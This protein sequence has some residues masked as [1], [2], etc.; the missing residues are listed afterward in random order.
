MLNQKRRKQENWKTFSKQLF[1]PPETY[2]KK[3]YKLEALFPIKLI[4]S[5]SLLK[6]AGTV[7][8]VIR[9]MKASLSEGGEADSGL[10]FERFA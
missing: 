9:T 10:I 8:N 3:N 2:A 6:I 4:Q 7:G 1:L 5:H